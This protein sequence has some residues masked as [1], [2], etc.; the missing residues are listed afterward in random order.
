[1]SLFSPL[2][3]VGPALQ[4]TN[5]A[6]RGIGST[7]SR[8]NPFRQRTNNDA[9]EVSSPAQALSQALSP[10]LLSRLQGIEPGLD[11]RVDVDDALAQT[12][13]DLLPPGLLD[14]A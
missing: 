8:I 13:A 7:L 2:Q 6:L 4:V 5:V 1:M 3:L 12:E 9:A 11:D 10:Q 14:Y